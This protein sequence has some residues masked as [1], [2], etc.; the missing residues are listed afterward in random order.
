MAVEYV[1]HCDKCDDVRGASFHS[2]AVARQNSQHLGWHRVHN[3]DICPE[4]WALGYRGP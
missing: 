3:Y 4:C 2:A 1:I